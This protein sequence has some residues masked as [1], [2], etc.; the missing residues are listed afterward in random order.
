MKTKIIDIICFVGGSS[1]FTYT[2]FDFHISSGSS[3][4][5]RDTESFPTYY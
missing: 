5:S 2:L 3:I 4:G 1:L